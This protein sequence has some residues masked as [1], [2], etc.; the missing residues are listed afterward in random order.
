[1]AA[2]PEGFLKLSTFREVLDENKRISWQ[3]GAQ[4]TQRRILVD[5]LQRRF[6]Q[7]P[8]TMVQ[9]IKRTESM[10]V[11]DRWLNEILIAND[12]ADTELGR[13]S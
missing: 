9:R 11:L 6:P 1:M 3:E 13:V 12:L 8:E 2:P 7:A 10:D 4:Q 5:Q